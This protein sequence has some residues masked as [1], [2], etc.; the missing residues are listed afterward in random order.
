MK[1]GVS[2][3]GVGAVSVIGTLILHDNVAAEN[4]V[5]LYVPGGMLSM[6]ELPIPVKVWI[7]SPGRDTFIIHGEP[8]PEGDISTAAFFMQDPAEINVAVTSGSGMMEIVYAIVWVPAS[9]QL[10]SVK[11]T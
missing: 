6:N 11:V 4:I 7:V 2:E 5:I 10:L 3:T 1:V 9:G 8:P